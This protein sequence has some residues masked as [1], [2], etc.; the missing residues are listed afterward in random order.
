MEEMEGEK[1]CWEEKQRGLWQYHKVHEKKA[2]IILEN[3][4][5]II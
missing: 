1:G 3:Q 4:L 2:I 5:H